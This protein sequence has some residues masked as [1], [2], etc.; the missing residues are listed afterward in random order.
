MSLTG[1]LNFVKDL[2][3]IRP[4]R[5]TESSGRIELRKIQHWESL[6]TLRKYFPDFL[7]SLGVNL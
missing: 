7:Q 2:L 1:F 5:N 4:S 6:L 3:E